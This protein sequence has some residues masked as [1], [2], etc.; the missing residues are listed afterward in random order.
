MTEGGNPLQRALAAS[1]IPIPCSLPAR[2]EPFTLEN[3]PIFG[4]DCVSEAY[5]AQPLVS[6]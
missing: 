3:F 2:G 6:N 5:R 4:K 1:V